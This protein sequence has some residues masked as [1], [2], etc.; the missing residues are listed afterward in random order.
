MTTIFVPAWDFAQD[1]SFV[2]NG[3]ATTTSLL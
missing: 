2:G 1:Y 3:V